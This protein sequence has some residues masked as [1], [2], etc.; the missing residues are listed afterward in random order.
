MDFP[1]NMIFFSEQTFLLGYCNTV[2]KI[3]AD[4]RGPFQVQCIIPNMDACKALCPMNDALK[5]VRPKHSKLCKTNHN[6]I[7]VSI[8]PYFTWPYIVTRGDTVAG[9]KFS[10]ALDD[11][12]VATAMQFLTWQLAIFN[13]LQD[14]SPVPKQWVICQL[15]L[16]S[17]LGHP[18]HFHYISLRCR[19]SS[20][21]ILTNYNSIITFSLDSARHFLRYLSF[22]SAK[23]NVFATTS[24]NHISTCY[25]RLRSYWILI[26]CAAITVTIRVSNI[27]D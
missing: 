1:P 13:E 20:W 11:Q 10:S 8:S 22:L 24:S 12:S 2:R 27:F 7:S 4:R 18:L 21:L 17:K 25:I 16:D 26:S 14:G 9:V 6:F 23:I 15:I 19:R 5:S 3:T